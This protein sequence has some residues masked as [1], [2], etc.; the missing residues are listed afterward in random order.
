MQCSEKST[1]MMNDNL[2]R[3]RLSL[4]SKNFKFTRKETSR[5]A[6]TRKTI[7]N[8]IIFLMFSDVF[9]R[10]QEETDNCC[11]TEQVKIS[12]IVKENDETIINYKH[13]LPEQGNAKNHPAK[14]CFFNQLINVAACGEN[15]FKL[16][17]L[18]NFIESEKV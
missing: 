11:I 7:C 17:R 1:N 6:C 13:S 15:I 2:V 18:I 4:C 3:D 8:A 14:L 9:N 12:D 5:Y 10:R 16:Q